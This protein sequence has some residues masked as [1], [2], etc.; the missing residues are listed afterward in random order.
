MAILVSIAATPFVAGCS[1]KSEAACGNAALK[2]DFTPVGQA[3][4]DPVVAVAIAAA[5]K[6]TRSSEAVFSADHFGYE[7]RTRSD[8]TR[9]FQFVPKSCE[10][11]GGVTMCVTPSLKPQDVSASE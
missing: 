7:G 9:C 4:R 8:G 10:V 6:A 11:G 5:A 1:G 3:G 2:G